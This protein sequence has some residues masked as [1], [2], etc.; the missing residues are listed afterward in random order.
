MSGFSKLSILVTANYKPFVNKMKELR[1][2]MPTLGNDF[3]KG[4]IQ[5]QAINMAVG[6]MKETVGT[7]LNFQEEMANSTAIFGDLTTEQ[8]NKMSYAALKASGQVR[9]SQDEIA[10]G[11]FY[12]GS[13]GKN[14]TTSLREIDDVARFATAGRFDLATA[15]EKLA[16]IQ[17]VFSLTSKNVIEDEKGMVRVSD[18]LSRANKQAQA[19]VLQ[20]A[21]AL[22]NNLGAEFRAVG[23]SIEEATAFVA[24]FAKVGEKGEKAGTRGAIVMRDLQTK[25]IQNRQ[26]FKDAGIAVY[27]YNGQMRHMWEILKDIEN[28]FGKLTPEMR[29]AQ[30]LQLGFTTKSVGAITQIIGL[31]GA[32]KEYYKDLKNA[33][34]F[35]QELADKNMNSLNAQFDRLKNNLVSAATLF[36]GL[37]NDVDGLKSANDRLND[38]LSWIAEWGLRI[39]TVF[40][41]WWA[42]QKDQFDIYG[43]L[44]DLAVSTVIVGVSIVWKAFKGLFQGIKELGSEALNYVFSFGKDG[45]DLTNVEYAFKR[46]A[47]GIKAEVETYYEMQK[48]NAS[49]LVSTFG[50]NTIKVLDEYMVE[51]AKIKKMTE[52][53]ANVAGSS[54]DTGSDS[55]FNVLYKKG[56]SL[57]DLIVRKTNEA[58]VQSGKMLEEYNK[59]WERQR[60]INRDNDPFIQQFRDAVTEFVPKTIAGTFGGLA[61]AVEKGSAEAY[62][63]SIGGK[64]TEAKIEENTK[65]SAETLKKIEKSLKTTYI[66]GTS[67]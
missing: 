30:L 21:D 51:S 32:M 63:I 19:S 11:Y 25:A 14:F 13:A 8:Y 46:A 59:G 39:R 60:E 36:V 9:L 16:D 24:A 27:G 65:N 1:S 45:F 37:G 62:R 49:G 28:A 31:S 4:M 43:R 7:M 10:K 61:A 2:K 56:S 35:T 58:Y 5:Y 54:G 17:N 48:K 26:A 22:T 55:L 53:Q 38:S 33:S 50:E 12:L 34:G 41:L 20:F 64:S 44:I 67:L 47:Q 3:A 42:S 23:K 15:T 40:K 6:K 66:M 29:R 57:I 52:D 18:V